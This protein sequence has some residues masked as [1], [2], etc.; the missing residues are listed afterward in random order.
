MK[1]LNKIKLGELDKND[2]NRILG[3]AWLNVNVHESQIWNPLETIPPE[4]SENPQ[5][6]ITWLLSQPE[7]FSFVCGQILG[8]EIWP[9]QGLMLQDLWNHRFPML[10]G[11]RGLSK[12][13]TLAL[14]ALLRMILLPGRKLVITGAAFRQS[15]IIF[16]YM[17]TIWNNA[18]L[19]RS[20]SN[21]DRDGPSHST[22]MWTFRLGESVCNAIPLGNG[23]RIRG[24]RAND[25]I[26]DEFS[27]I[28]REI[29]ETVIVGFSAVK[30]SPLDSMKL[31]ATRRV[32]EALGIVLPEY[33]DVEL[34]RENQTI[35]SGTAYYDFNH[36]AEYWKR[37]K[38]I[39]LSGGNKDEWS[40]IFPDDIASELSW[41]DFCIL[42]I[43][44]ELIPKGFMDE[45]QVAR[46]RVT[47]HAGIYEMEYGAV[48][49]KDSAGFF[50]RSLIEQCVASPAN[51]I[52][53]LD[54]I[55]IIFGPRIIGDKTHKYVFAIDPASEVDNFAITI[56]EIHPTHRRIVYCWT[57]NKKDYKDRIKVGMAK[58]GDFYGFCARKIRNLMKV[59]PCVA[60]AIDGQ[61]GG[62]Q[63]AERLHDK[64]LLEANEVPLWPIIDP[65]KPSDTDG[66]YGEHIIHIIEFSNHEWVVYANNGLRGDF[67]SKF[68]IFPYNDAIDVALAM[69][70]KE[71]SGQLYDS[72]ED[73]I[74]ELEELKNELST[75]IMMPTATGKDKWDTPDTKLPGAKK[76]RMRKDRYSA[77]LMANAV[78]REMSMVQPK[79]PYEF[80]AGWAQTNTLDKN[81]GPAFVGPAWLADALNNL[82]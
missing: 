36:F 48:F 28:I 39:I 45:V 82:Y 46:S 23:S 49:A 7:Y 65:K 18:P 77:L 17:E 81:T 10:I 67:E 19:L 44:F 52:K 42:R 37:W 74:F 63:V 15:K 38:A 27:S 31:S 75:I 30:S 58:D 55:P 24:L 40:K 2:I 56:L 25:T 34:M 16:E 21:K 20:I 32:A 26:A 72:L 68:C 71:N 35:I 8:I 73:C 4:Y 33:E 9:M 79:R 61:G 43:P 47:I 41:K 69:N 53:I 70:D 6:W 29:F 5:T 50:K 12:S 11:S 66:Q 60:I 62:K 76:D 57:T 14:Y 54:D 51:A 1:S 59:F 13:F 64:S 22:D 3:D 80:N 78:A